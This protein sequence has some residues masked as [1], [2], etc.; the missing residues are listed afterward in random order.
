MSD[1]DRAAVHVQLLVRDADAVR[2]IEHLAREGFVQLPDFD[3]VGLEAVA[4][5]KA[6]DGEDRTDSHFIGL[7]SGRGKAAED[8]E[9]LD[10]L[11]RRDIGAHHH[12]SRCA[13]GELRGVPAVMYF[14]S[15]TCWPPWKTG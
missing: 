4:L 13:V 10:A 7:A 2:A 12:A 11:L 9:R 6:R 14:P 5:Q 3:V 1:R 15:F 8:T